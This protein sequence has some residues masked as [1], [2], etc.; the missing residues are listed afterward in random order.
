VNAENELVTEGNSIE[1]GGQLERGTVDERRQP[2]RC[3]L[4]GSQDLGRD[5]ASPWIFVFAVLLL[6][7]GP[8]LFFFNGNR[9]CRGCGLRLKLP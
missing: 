4:C 9:Y 7:I 2:Q 1:P 3:P 6:P 8:L 5:S